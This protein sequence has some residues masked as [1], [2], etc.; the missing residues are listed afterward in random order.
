MNIPKW[1]AVALAILAGFNVVM[2]I[3]SEL[4]R[5]QFMFEESLQTVMF[6]AWIADDASDWTTYAYAAKSYA[7]VLDKAEGYTRWIGWINPFAKGS[8]EAYWQ[9]AHV[10]LNAMKINLCKVEPLLCGGLP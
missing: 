6:A 8:Y 7:W 1:L 9:S 3:I 2:L 10:F 4:T 5:P